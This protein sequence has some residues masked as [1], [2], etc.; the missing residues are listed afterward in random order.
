MLYER[1]TTSQVPATAREQVSFTDAEISHNLGVEA[2]RA[3]DISTARRHF[4]EA[5]VLDPALL[6]SRSALA[7][8]FLEAGELER[9]VEAAALVIEQRPDNARALRILVDAQRGLG[10]EPEAR[11]AERELEKLGEGSE[12]PAVLYNL[13]TEAY[14]L[15]DS[16]AA[17]ERFE[18]A[19]VLDSELVPAL[20]G[21]ALARY[22]LGQ[23]QAAAEAAERVLTARPDHQ[24]SL[25]IRYDAYRQL[26]DESKPPKH[27]RRWARSILPPLSSNCWRKAVSCSRRA[28]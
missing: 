24:N 16:A 5:I 26:G 27:S 8:L 28:H 4:E 20:S 23:W 25:R 22:R 3:G 13:G 11:K 15:G 9:A 7:G 17:A 1:D 2:A 21:L 19:L 14:E 10:N 18:E 6:P 12:D